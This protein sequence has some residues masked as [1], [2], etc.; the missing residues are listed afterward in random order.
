MN[1]LSLGLSIL[2]LVVVLVRIIVW[3]PAGFVYAQGQGKR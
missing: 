3:T 1:Y 2:L